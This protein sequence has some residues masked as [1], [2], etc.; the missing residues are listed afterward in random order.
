MF[1]RTSTF[2][3]YICSLRLQPCLPQI[4]ILDCLQKF[5]RF[6]CFLFFSL[7]LTHL[8]LFNLKKNIL[9]ISLIQE[10]DVDNFNVLFIRREK[11]I[12]STMYCIT[13]HTT[14][15]LIWHR[16]FYQFWHKKYWNHWKWKLQRRQFECIY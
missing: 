9:W 16:F 13:Q 10:Y 14:N 6:F 2:K 5:L 15:K 11:K 4:Q 7:F 3:T 12:I 1:K 8:L